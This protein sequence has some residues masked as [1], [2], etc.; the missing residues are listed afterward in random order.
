M[1]SILICSLSGA[2]G[3]TTTALAMALEWPGDGRS[4]TVVEADTSGGDLA[5]RF[6]LPYTPGLVE[7]AG[8]ARRRSDTGQLLAE[9]TARLAFAADTVDVVLAPPGGVAARVALPALAAPAGVLA[10]DDTHL[11]LV[12]AGR[13]DPTGPVWPLLSTVDV[14]VVLVPSRVDALARLQASLPQLRHAAAERLLIVLTAADPYTPAEVAELFDVA[15]CEQVL[16]DDPMAAAVLA[17]RRVPRRRWRRRLAL[18]AVAAQLAG[19]L[20]ARLGPVPVAAGTETA[21][22]TEAVA[23]AVTP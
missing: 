20:S 22:D 13:I 6:A 18:P 15:V 11:V 17:G 2:P 5:A 1:S 23:V 3:V 19:E 16:P 12:D 10:G 4:P 9:H 7:L 8:A 14:V 21:F